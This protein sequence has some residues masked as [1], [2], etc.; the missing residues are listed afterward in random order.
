MYRVSLSAP[1][2][3]DDFRDA[4]RRLI[5]ADVPPAQIAWEAGGDAGLF[6]DA[7]LPAGT[8]AFAVPAGFVALAQH[9]ICHNDPERLAMLYT[10]LWRITHGERAL[11]HDAADPL[12][13]RLKQMEKSA[14][15]D[16][17]KMTAFVRFRRTEDEGG[18]HYIAWFEPEH[19][20]LRQVSPFFVDRFAGMRW[21]I[22]TPQGSAHWNLQRLSFGPAL[23]REHAPQGDALEDWWR[24]YYRSIFN[25]ARAN[26]AAMRAEMPKKYWHNLPEAT[27]IPNLLADA[28]HRTRSMLDAPPMV[29][30]QATLWQPEPTEVPQ[31]G[32]LKALKAEAAG[33]RRC[34]LYKNA[35][36]T[37]FG[38]GAAH[39]PV[40]FVGEQPGDQE[41]LAGKPFV[42][43]AGQMFDRALAEAG[44][45][46]KRVY[47]TNA[48]KHFKYEPR[49]KRR[50][51]QKPN[52]AEIDACRWWLD[53][54]LKLIKPQV[55]VALGATA[56]RSLTGRAVTISRERGRIADLGNGRSGLITVHPS[57]LLRLPDPE[58]KA[59]EYARFVD[60]LRVV[61]GKLP[62]ICRAA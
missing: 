17:H 53:G 36:Q 8:A 37:V 41:D 60:D 40:V 49:G 19:H 47:V 9:V 29:P 62:D 11:L 42:G 6:G 18:E 35:T 61:A 54:E 25:P 58:A 39:A 13:H 15:R 3:F 59:R 55:T 56:A 38:E 31:A 51:H 45:D 32:S 14:G 57:F 48:V 1:D 22:L 44:I 30:R 34:P 24:T 23:G 50:I 16:Y 2:A 33:C 21:T 12:I 26:P 7:A 10:L 46:R 43:P 4:A 52:N 28:G 20:I 5:A 27:L